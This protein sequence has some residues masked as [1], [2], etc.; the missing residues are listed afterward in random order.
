MNRRP[1]Y[2]VEKSAWLFTPSN[3]GP[4]EEVRQWCL[5]ELLRCYGAEIGK[6]V[7]EWPVKIGRSPHRADIVILNA[8]NAP[9]CVI[10]CKELKHKKHEAAM[11]Q[12]VS[13]AKAGNG[14]A[15]FAICV[16]RGNQSSVPIETS[17]AFRFKTVQSERSD[18]RVF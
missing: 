18:A 17:P 5:H 11:K 12:A 13:Y 4:E 1:F 16:F 8:H 9:Y 6:I 2:K 10:E 7:T 3:P 14:K 15:Q